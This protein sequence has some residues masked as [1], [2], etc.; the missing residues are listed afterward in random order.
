MR[1]PSTARCARPACFILRLCSSSPRHPGKGVSP[2]AGVHHRTA[3]PELVDY[4]GDGPRGF[5]RGD[6]GFGWKDLPM[7]PAVKPR[8][9]G[10]RDHASEAD[11][12]FR[13]DERAVRLVSP[14][15][16]RIALGVPPYPLLPHPFFFGLLAIA[17]AIR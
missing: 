14:S 5:A 17:A 15:V 4:V 6:D 2:H 10:W 11:P 1:R 3:R 13:G 8:D 12:R 7:G 16:E 9:D